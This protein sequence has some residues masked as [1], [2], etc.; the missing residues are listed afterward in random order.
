MGVTLWWDGPSGAAGDMLLGSLLAAGADWASMAPVLRDALPGDWTVTTERVVAG[1][2]AATRVDVHDPSEYLHVHNHSHE[3]DHAHSHGH[4]HE[5]DHAHGH[6]HP[7]GHD[8]AHEHRHFPSHDGTSC[9]S[10]VPPV[11]NHPP[12]R[13]DSASTHAPHR[14]LADLLAVA[15]HPRV[16]PRARERA[17]HVFCALAE[18]E[19]AVHGSTPEQVHF[20][21]V[22]GV[23]TVID[24]LGVCLA[25]EQ[26]DVDT[27]LVTPPFVGAGTVR[28]AHGVLPV[29][30]P[31]VAMLLE[32]HGLSF[33]A[34]GG[35]GEMLTPT[36]AA[37]LAVLGR[38]IDGAP[39]LR[40][41]A[42]GYGA[43]RKVWPDRPNVVRAWIG[44][45][46]RSA[47]PAHR[48]PDVGVD[49]TEDALHA[50]ATFGFDKRPSREAENSHAVLDTS[51]ADAAVATTTDDDTR[52]DRVRV[53]EALVDD[54]TP[55]AVAYWLD[56]TLAAGAL[57]AWILPA[58]MKKNRPGWQLSAM[59]YAERG[60]A[61][62]EVLVR[63]TST[64]GWRVRDVAR[65]TLPRQ[66]DTV[67]VFGQPVRVKKA[68]WRGATVRVQPEFE[69]ARRVSMATGHSLASVFDAARRAAGVP[70]VDGDGVETT[71]PQ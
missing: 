40:V 44:E 60:G 38:E 7:H 4:P 35:D 31:A 8:H 59:A 54:M 69:D 48:A 46:V 58:T 57:D 21:E 6:D 36:G 65:R 33:R 41:R 20:H 45:P 47:A 71:R 12:S 37:L 10:D 24:V 39:R 17:T 51:D 63:E 5:H 16:P 26:L 13:S 64:L 68:F 15:A 34:G 18:A 61:V 11:E 2:L 52:S 56:R 30:P 67:T 3:H 28:C 53:W 55:E 29:P 9:P 27:I 70:S 50:N 14:H 25:L 49:G 42:V 43:G 62:E 19:A 66:L 32:R 22:S 23:D 1:G